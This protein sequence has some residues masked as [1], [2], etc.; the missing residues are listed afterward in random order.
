M[1]FYRRVLLLSLGSFMLAAPFTSTHAQM[2]DVAELMAPGPIPDRVLGNE[3][4]P[5]TI[6]EYASPSC[7][8]CARFYKED[9]PTFKKKYIDTGKVRFIMRGM[10][11]SPTAA[12]AFALARCQSDDKYYSTIELLFEQQ[13]NWASEKPKSKALLAVAKQA[14]FTRKSFKACMADKKLIQAIDDDVHK[15][16][17]KFGVKSLPTFFINGQMMQGD[18]TLDGFDKALEPLLKNS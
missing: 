2:V 5:I 10:P 17:E 4:A 15:A 16:K 9:F 18:K 8:H 12:S 3:K 6:V 11:L 13:T 14:G 1:K 7:T